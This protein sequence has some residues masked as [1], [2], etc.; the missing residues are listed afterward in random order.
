MFTAFLCVFCEEA[1]GLSYGSE[2]RMQNQGSGLDPHPR[3]PRPPVDLVPPA[4]RT[5]GDGVVL[6]PRPAKMEETITIVWAVSIAT[7]P[8]I[9]LSH[10]VFFFVLCWWWGLVWAPWCNTFVPLMMRSLTRRKGANMTLISNWGDKKSLGN[11][12]VIRRTTSIINKKKHPGNL[13]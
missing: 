8:L 6:L 1:A 13:K 2:T 10:W 7:Q 4:G 5:L 12:D 3:R 9:S 11:S